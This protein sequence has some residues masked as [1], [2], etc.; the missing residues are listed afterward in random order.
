MT[1][2][3]ATSPRPSSPL[4]VTVLF[5]RWLPIAALLTLI[6]FAFG[7]R[8]PV[9]V[10]AAYVLF[11]WRLHRER[12]GATERSR[13]SSGLAVTGWVTLAAAV[14]AVLF[15]G[16]GFIFGAFGAIAIALPRPTRLR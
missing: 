3:M 5:L 12:H 13:L 1:G 14:G 4:G 2:V 9:A 16:L 15:G 6:G 8:A 11:F 7:W 10:I